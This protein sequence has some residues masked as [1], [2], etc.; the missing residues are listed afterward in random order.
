MKMISSS[1]P[2]GQGAMV[3]NDGPIIVYASDKQ[4]TSM[5]I[6][7]QVDNKT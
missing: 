5:F 4:T 7:E 2:H 6:V 1:H 3:P